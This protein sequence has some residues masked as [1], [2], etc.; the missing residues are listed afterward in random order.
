MNQTIEILTEKIKNEIIRQPKRS[1]QFDEPL[2][3]SGL[4]DS[5]N[6]VDLALM[7]E[8]IFGVHIDDYEL[9]SDTFDTIEDLAMLIIERQESG[10]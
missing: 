5:F 1:L 10:V 7:V 4:I 6:L 3:S 9:N 8:E 2:I